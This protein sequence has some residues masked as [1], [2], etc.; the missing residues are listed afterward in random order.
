MSGRAARHGDRPTG[1]SS[2]EAIVR[3][4]APRANPAPQGALY[5]VAEPVDML[6]STDIL[7][8][9]QNFQ[10]CNIV[11]NY[12]L[13]WN[14]VRIIQRVGRINRADSGEFHPPDDRKA[15]VL[16][17]FP[18]EQLTA[19]LDQCLTIVERNRQKLRHIADIV[20]HGTAVLFEDEHTNR[21]L[22]DRLAQAP[23]PSVYRELEQQQ[24]Q[25]FGLGAAFDDDEL[26]AQEYRRLAAQQPDLAARAAEL[27]LPVVSCRS[28]AAG[29]P[30]TAALF[31]ETSGADLRLRWLW[32]PGQPGATIQGEKVKSQVLRG[33][34]CLPRALRRPPSMDLEQVQA[35]MTDWLRDDAR[36]DQEARQMALPAAAVAG[37]SSFRRLTERIDAE[38]VKLPPQTLADPAVQQQVTDV[39]QWLAA[40]DQ[41]IFAQR[42]AATADVEQIL[43]RRI[44][45]RELL[46][47][48]AEISARYPVV[49]GMQLA[50]SPMGWELVCLE[51]IRTEEVIPLVNEP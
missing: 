38:V 37:K 16:A 9:G 27:P 44:G 25:A 24:A 50:T 51:E 12:D 3:A 43:Q 45:S 35:Q 10:D 19:I 11:I 33:L 40:V 30:G 14:P 26:L 13:T 28:T 32:L 42:D 48:A 46:S 49:P 31:R 7:A 18:E 15:H 36:R 34:R 41:L 17:F 23:G 4:F 39:N 20:G 5:D 22:F 6:I 21:V 1:E 2:T 47:A 29:P 8:E